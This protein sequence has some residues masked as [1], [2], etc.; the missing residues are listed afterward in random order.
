[1]NDEILTPTNWS[2]FDFGGAE[3]AGGLTFIEACDYL[4]PQRLARKWCAVCV[5]DE[6]NKPAPTQPTE[7]V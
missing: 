3:V 1:M 7:C 6:A 4:T 5:I 2:V